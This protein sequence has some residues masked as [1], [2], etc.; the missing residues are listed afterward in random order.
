MAEINQIC[1]SV[2]GMG[3]FTVDSY[4]G[5]WFDNECMYWETHL[6]MLNETHYVSLYQS[7]IDTMHEEDESEHFEISLIEFKRIMEQ[8]FQAYRIM[9][10]EL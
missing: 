5:V 2:A 3:N 9:K 7:F 1:I 6:S 10:G 8:L 4:M